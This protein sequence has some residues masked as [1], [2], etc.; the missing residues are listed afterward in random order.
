MAYGSLPSRLHGRSNASR[1]V[2]DPFGKAIDSSPNNP[3]PLP[4]LSLNRRTSLD[5]PTRQQD[6][7]KRH[8][9]LPSIKALR[10]KFTQGWKWSSHEQGKKDHEHVPTKGNSPKKLSK[11]GR[12][13][14]GRV[15]GESQSK[16]GEG[17]VKS[18]SMPSLG[19]IAHE[20]ERDKPP[21]P[22][23]LPLP[24]RGGQMSVDALLAN[25]TPKSPSPR[26]PSPTSR[27]PRS[28]SITSPQRRPQTSQNLSPTSQPLPV[29]NRISSDFARSAADPPL[30]TLRAP[31]IRDTVTLNKPAQAI[32]R[33]SRILP[34]ATLPAAFPSLDPQRP[35]SSLS[36]SHSVGPSISS[37][38]RMK[39]SSTQS[40]TSV[41]APSVDSQR[42]RSSLLP[43]EIPRD[44]R[45][46]KD[47]LAFRRHSLSP[48]IPSAANSS[49]EASPSK[50]DELKSEEERG[51]K[52]SNFLD[53]GKRS[54]LG[55]G[56][57][58]V[59]QRRRPS[60]PF[61][62]GFEEVPFRA[63]GS[64]SDVPTTQ[65]STTHP[66]SP[67]PVLIGAR[68]NLKA[69]SIPARQPETPSPPSQIPSH[70]LPPITQIHSTVSLPEP[71]PMS[72]LTPAP[73]SSPTRKLQNS[74]RLVTLTLKRSLEHLLPSRKSVS[75]ESRPP[76]LRRSQSETSIG[77]ILTPLLRIRE[78]VPARQDILTAGGTRETIN[79]TAGASGSYA[80]RLRELK[81]L[82]TPIL[83]GDEKRRSKFETVEPELD[84]TVRL[85]SEERG[86]IGE[87]RSGGDDEQDD[88]SRPVSPTHFKN[89]PNAL[90]PFRLSTYLDFLSPNKISPNEEPQSVL[91]DAARS[92]SVPSPLP[93]P[94]PSP[95]STSLDSSDPLS[96][97]DRPL[98]LGQMEQEI[99]KMERELALAGTPRSFF[100]DDSNLDLDLDSG[101]PIPCPPLD[102]RTSAS[103]TSPLPGD[104]QPIT[105]RT[106]R[107]WSIVEVEKAYERMRRM[108]G[109]SSSSRIYT[110]SEVDGEVELEPSDPREAAE[111][112]DHKKQRDGVEVL[113]NDGDVFSDPTRFASHVSI[114]T[115]C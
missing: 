28:S 81:A 53:S 79:E 6:S 50:S 60:K 40:I 77:T 112:S 64:A 29:F 72:P 67:N 42:K 109:S 57:G 4:F 99:T 85:A 62:G 1:S 68:R 51:R 12:S 93:L 44:D 75:D 103:Q 76:Q 36:R 63:K 111:T 14:V 110:P 58:G 26:S 45:R 101:S 49:P 74:A 31:Q 19:P 102:I 73:Q 16:E 27:L 91:L 38:Q 3:E 24:L 108:L 30:S 96:P 2:S 5:Y 23:P 92:Q 97:I 83:D 7:S 114:C 41:H 71:L 95:H 15:K 82:R 9:R 22:L 113:A 61:P 87:G 48:V 21:L 104:D 47:D 100:T 90:H 115:S 10:D 66:L 39:R 46:M 11:N 52:L 20:G 98:T 8:Q 86:L 65:T 88:E 80:E 35:L 89:S 25:S 78:T 106:A 69:I 43:T 17:M 70:E 33:H 84:D 13:G 56:I 37:D 18:A 105:P 55:L 32:N 59:P 34:G 54:S 94:L 107:K